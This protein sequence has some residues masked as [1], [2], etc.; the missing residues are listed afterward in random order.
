MHQF[1]D[2]KEIKKQPFR[3]LYLI[4]KKIQ[5]EFASTK[6]VASRAVQEGWDISKYSADLKEI[7]GL[8][9][10]IYRNK[11]LPLPNK[12]TKGL[13]M[14]LDSKM[15]SFTHNYFSVKPDEFNEYYLEMAK[16]K[17]A[18]ICRKQGLGKLFHRN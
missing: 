16:I 2:E 3:A 8:I 18:L 1:L 12:D 9:E 4:K 17:A 13:W 5:S 14:N 15:L 10:Q 7:V 6:H 11:I